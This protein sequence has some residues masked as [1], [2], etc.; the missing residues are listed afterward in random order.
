MSSCPVM[1]YIVSRK[2]YNKGG[3]MLM[4]K[5]FSI[6]S[7]PVDAE[8]F[9]GMIIGL[10]AGRDGKEIL[11]QLEASFCGSQESSGLADQIVGAIRPTPEIYDCVKDIVLKAAE[12]EDALTGLLCV[13]KY[14]MAFDEHGIPQKVV[15]ANSSTTTI[16]RRI[17]NDPRDFEMFA[18][19]S[20]F[21]ES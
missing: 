11:N 18:T 5:D 13:T 7:I 4:E 3:Y 21:T 6:V 14:S 19:T 8:S 10:C 12:F 17:N 2:I 9:L 1:I 16:V 20:Y 15:G